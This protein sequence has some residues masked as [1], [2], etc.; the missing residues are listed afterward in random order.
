MDFQTPEWVCRYMVDLLPAQKIK[1]VLEPTPG[2][3]NIVKELL[4]REI[5]SITAAQDF[6]AVT[7]RYDAIVMNPPFTPMALGYEILY[8]VMDMSDVVIALMP[9]LTIINS[10]QRTRDIIGFGLKSI[11]HLPRSVFPGS[12]V[13]TCILS[14]VK[15]YSG[16]TLFLTTRK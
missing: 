2:E 15:G 1:A 16:R 12:R 3:G 14:M 9:W 11:T 8:R 13:Q 10:E 5:Y 6:F 7:G 4:R